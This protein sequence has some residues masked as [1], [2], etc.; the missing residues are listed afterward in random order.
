[1][2]YASASD[3]Y[4]YTHALIAPATAPGFTTTT[5]PTLAEVTVWLSSGCSVINARLGS[6]G[7]GAIPT[8]S[9]A[10]DLAVAAN[11][12]Y[13]AWMAERSRVNARVSADERTRADMFKRDFEFH[14]NQLVELDLSRMGVSRVSGVYMGGISVSDKTS[15]ENN[16]DRVAPRF[17]RGMN[18]NPERLDP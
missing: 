8:T 14:L 10:Y 3:V 7:Y 16:T 1:M 18:R 15:V 2:A 5:C 6:L 12:L 4:A 17:K 13:G 9:A 11:A